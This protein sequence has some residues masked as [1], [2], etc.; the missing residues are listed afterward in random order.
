MRKNEQR[1]IEELLSAYI[2]GELSDRRRMEVRR[3]VENNA[4]A[5]ALLKSL[6]KQKELLNAMPTSPAPA[7]LAKRV[8][9]VARRAPEPRISAE[10]VPTVPV[11]PAAQ[12]VEEPAAVVQEPAPIV[13]EP[14]PFVEE[15]APVAELTV[16]EPAAV[17]EIPL[18]EPVVQ[19]PA[20][21]VQEPAPGVEIPVEE[22]VPVAETPMEE[23]A[24]VA[25][26][27]VE[28]T[29]PVA[30]T[31]IE[32]AAS[33]V[34][35]VV[36]E[37]LPVVQESEPAIAAAASAE[38]EVRAAVPPQIPIAPAVSSAALRYKGE[39]QLFMRRILTAAAM[40]FIPVVIL[41]L[42]VWGIVGPLND[43]EKVA[44][45]PPPAPGI[46]EPT[47]GPAVSFPL[48]AS[49]Y[50]TT[51]QP[52]QMDSFIH[53]AIYNHDLT[54]NAT[55]VGLGRNDRSYEIR[56]DRERIVAF[57]SELATVWDKCESAA[58][59]VH[60][61][62]MAL[63]ARIENVRP[64]QAIALYQGDVFLDPLQYA[65]QMDQMNRLMQDIGNYPGV[66][67]TPIMPQL[68]S[69]TRKTTSKTATADTPDAYVTL[70]V[71]IQSR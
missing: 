7:G 50:L 42:V 40:L 60:G 63:N 19:E 11:E 16:D 34:E 61:Q 33:V 57:L 8:L 14:A 45:T 49:L 62:T 15:P 20:P 71:N 30:E 6:Q 25:E 58:M 44:V 68:T 51:S 46:D 36:E 3:L 39:Q 9:V 31:S 69:G 38:A 18:E 53:K 17:V 22:P 13:Q 4:Y 35:P 5:A 66:P 41:G 67:G 12:V 29:A 32:E 43:T 65:R 64:D 24:Q 1:K 23:A 28:E 56:A 59:T 21:V 37:P 47:P 54:N 52:M 26:T 48:T 55:T 2:D 70:F 27:P 10:P